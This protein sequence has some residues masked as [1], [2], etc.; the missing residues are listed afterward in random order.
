MDEP[1][2]KYGDVER[3]LATI[4]VD[5]EYETA[6][7]NS[8][9]EYA[10]FE[11]IIDMIEGVRSEK[12]YDWQSDINIPVV[13]SHLLTEAASWTSY[14][15][16]RD[17]VEIYLEGET[18]DKKKCEAAKKC[19]NK[20]LNMKDV[21]HYHKYMRARTISWLMGQ[22]YIMGYW[23]QDI[24]KKSI[25]QPPM[26]RVIPTIGPTGE[27]M[28]TIMMEPQPDMSIE[29]IVTDRF[30]YDTLDPR[31]V[32]TDNSYCYSIQQ[33]PWVIVRS[34]ETYESLKKDAARMGYFN[35]ELVKKSLSDD[36]TAVS[37]ETYNKYELKSYINAIQ[38]PF[39]LLTRF[40]KIWAIVKERDE[41]EVPIDI[42]P[43]YDEKGEI[44]E[45]AELVEG[46]LAFAMPKQQKILIR[47]QPTPFIDALGRPYK[48][49]ARGWCYIHP[50]KDQGLS[51]GKNLH[52]IQIGVNDTFNVSNDRV[53]L[54]TMMT[55]MGQ[56]DAVNKNPTIYMAPGNVMQVDN[57][58]TDLKPIVIRDNIEGAWQQL[59]GLLTFAS[60]VDSIYPQTMGAI[61][62]E[63]GTTATEVTG[64]DTQANKRTNLKSLTYE[65]T[66]AVES[67]WMILQMVY[68]FARPETLVQ[69][70]GE[71][72]ADFDPNADY[73]YVPLS[74]SLESEHNKLRK[75]G[76]YDQM[77]GRLTGLAQIF[78]KEIAMIIAKITGK[79]MTLM[80]S[81]YQEIAELVNALG[82][83][84]PVLSEA[85]GPGA[86][87][88]ANQ[89]P[90][91]TSNQSGIEVG[92]ME[93]N[94]RG[95]Q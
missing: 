78:P 84:R 56:R 80:G 66:V 36:E 11:A 47:F 41:D 73:T 31:N 17:F 72:A 13:V 29:E 89:S 37:R 39:D 28:P 27:T 12:N 53:M 71:L 38:K 10:D 85:Q 42:E 82:K 79:Q 77:I 52:D 54:S 87:Q 43:G 57:I 55:F 94:A 59:N 32:F 7:I 49:L 14:F 4:V 45:K 15:Q 83:A 69:L 76:T 21:Y 6:K 3:V 22:C 19:I 86:T 5:K 46:I 81:E 44:K 90:P 48:P 26:R 20:S 64:A 18:G 70:V 60:Q 30:N 9:A 51:D 25:P 35:L 58:Q 50:T 40:G 88:I 75:V 8:S 61:S 16:T 33:K 68:R 62:G 2:A 67:Y 1:K 92:G 24:R 23:E 91:M 63:S 93:M 34:E 95:M 74:Q 65:Y